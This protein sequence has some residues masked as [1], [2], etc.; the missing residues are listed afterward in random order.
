MKTLLL[1]IWQLPQHILAGFYI[2]ALRPLGRHP[3]RDSTVYRVK[4]D[5][6]ICLGR[7]I[8]AGES[9]GENDLRHE[10]GHSIQSR[11]LGPLYLILVGIPSA[12]FN[13]LWDR[14]FHRAW[15]R[16]R[17][18]RW[19]YRRYP[20]AWADILGGADPGSRFSPSVPRLNR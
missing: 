3:F 10:Y 15:S 18:T 9:L 17:R 20:E 12:Y 13:H 16:E 4:Q 19:Y 14:I 7:Y 8:I 1:Y 6:G 2:L 11:I 5:M